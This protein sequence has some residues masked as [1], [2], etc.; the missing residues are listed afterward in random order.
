MAKYIDLEEL[1]KFPIRLD[2][3]D[4]ENGNF[5][6]VA[7]IETMIEYAECLPTIDAVEVVRCKDCKH[8]DMS[9]RYG[10]DRRICKIRSIPENHFYFETRPFGFCSYGIRKDVDNE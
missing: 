3:Y 4:K 2:H 6:F 8:W 10:D 7:G 9:S 5:D 1:L